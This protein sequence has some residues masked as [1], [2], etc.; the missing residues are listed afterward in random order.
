MQQG[1]LAATVAPDQAG[2]LAPQRKRQAI[3]QRAAVRGDE[4][5]GIQNEKCRHGE[6]PKWTDVAK[7]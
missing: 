7:R 4:V 3:E 1:R 6:L 5:N 2:P